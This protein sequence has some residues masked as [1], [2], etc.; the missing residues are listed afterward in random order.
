MKKSLKITLIVLGVLV[1]V[2]LLDTLQ[3]KVF[4]NSPL[5][6]IRKN[7]ESCRQQN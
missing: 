6:K 3:A 7:F 1:G 2:I 4:D 5:I